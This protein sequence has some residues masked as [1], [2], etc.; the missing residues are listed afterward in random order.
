MD[1]CSYGNRSVIVAFTLLL[2]SF[3]AK[4]MR[5]CEL[6]LPVSEE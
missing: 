3:H 5:E 6:I 4:S 1:D 2:G